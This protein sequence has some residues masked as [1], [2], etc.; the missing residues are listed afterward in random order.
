MING[1]SP[2]FDTA[3]KMMVDSQLRP[4]KVTDDRLIGAFSMLTRETFLPAALASRAYADEN[5]R[6]GN[7]RVMLAPMALARL[8]QEAD[9][10]A[11]MT[12]L[13][14]GA[15]TGYSAAI[16]TSTGAKIT[17]LESDADLARTAQTNG[18]SLVHGALAE[19]WS[20]NAPYDRII[21]EG[22]VTNLPETLAAQLA[23]GGRIVMVQDRGPRIGVA[24][25]GVKTAAGISFAPKFDCVASVLPGFAK[26]AAFVF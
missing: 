26:E 10:T 17:A 18:V 3:R 13:L 8:V 20:A 19:G 12:V 22:A 14:V 2:V 23:E 4:N 9:I 7:G 21:I 24:V 16:L 11:G 15:G 25:V 1:Q 6:L 5:I